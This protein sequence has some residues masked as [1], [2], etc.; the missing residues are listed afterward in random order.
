VKR[1]GY[2]IE[3]TA[4]CYQRR[5][6]RGNILFPIASSVLKMFPQSG[7]TLIFICKPEKTGA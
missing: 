6:K 5:A 1:H 4:A 7:G 3:L 2:R